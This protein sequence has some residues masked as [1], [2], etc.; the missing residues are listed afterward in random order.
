VVVVPAALA[1]R[2]HSGPGRDL[3]RLSRDFGENPSP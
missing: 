1:D 3:L 2:I